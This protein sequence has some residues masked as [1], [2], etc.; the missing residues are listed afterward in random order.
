MDARTT[1]WIG[2]LALS[3]LWHAALP[4]W[5][6]QAADQYAVAA[7]HYAAK[8]W[9]LA[10]TEFRELVERHPQSPRASQSR[11]YLAECLIQSGK[12]R[13]A[14]ETLAQ[15][16]QQE[17][18][19]QLARRALFRQGEAWHLA[20]E[21]KSAEPVLR[22][23]LESY[24]DDP[25]A[26]HALCYHGASLLALRQ[27]AEASE[28]FGQALRRG[29]TGSLEEMCRLGKGQSAEQLRKEDDAAQWYEGLLAAKSSKVAQ[30]A[31]LNLGAL[32]FRRGEFASAV[33]TLK[34]LAD[35]PADN[36]LREE[37]RYWTA[38]GLLQAG[39][40]QPAL[41]IL[42]PWTNQSGPR[43]E[44]AC[45]RAATALVSLNRADEA[46]ALLKKLSHDGAWGD[47]ALLAR[48]Q[49]AVKQQDDVAVE[50]LHQEFC[51]RFPRS[52]R[53]SEVAEI[54]ARRLDAAGKHAE[55]IELLRSRLGD[56][57][58]DDDADRR[59]RY[60]LALS[61][62]GQ[63]R[64]EDALRQ[65][66]LVLQTGD[67]ELKRRALQSQGAILVS[68]GRYQE[69]IAPLA[70]SLELNPGA[71]EAAVGRGNLA[72]CYARTG[73][74]AEAK[75]ID[76]EL[77]S[78]P[79]DVAR[80]LNLLALA[81]AAAAANQRDW[82]QRLWV[83]I[84]D[85]Q[86]PVEHQLQALYSLARSQLLAGQPADAI[87]TCQKLSDRQPSGLVRA[88]AQWLRAAS[89]EKLR[90]S[91]E[92]L[93]AYRILSEQETA[94]TPAA[95]AKAAQLEQSL[96]RPDEAIQL[97]RRLASQFPEAPESDAALYQAAWL[98]QAASR[99]QE[100][101]DCFSTLHQQYPASRYWADATYRLAA[102][103][104]KS[105]QNDAVRCLVTA[106][107]E[108]SETPPE[109]LA[110]AL[111]LDVQRGVAE[112]NWT[113]VEAAANEL[114]KRVPQSQLVRVAEFWLA[115]AAYRRQ[116]TDEAVR[117]FTAL[118]QR[119]QQGQ[120]PWLA[121]VPLRLGQLAAAARDWPAARRRVEQVRRDW[122]HGDH[123]QE[124]EYL[125]GR[126]LAAEARFDE[127]RQAYTRV[128]DA[129][130]QTKTETAA[131]AQW[132]I[133]ETFL[134]QE[135]H[136]DALRAYLRVEALFAY[137]RWQAAA[138]LEAGRCYEA[139]G[140]P[141]DAIAAYQRI[142]EK[143]G[144][145]TYCDEARKRLQSATAATSPPKNS[146][147]EAAPMFSPPSSATREA[148]V[149]YDSQG[150]KTQR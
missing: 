51:R 106:L 40:H 120:D 79:L 75:Q 145:S 18:D 129:D 121:M 127:A 52:P 78:Q 25:S 23:F 67:L 140:R 123:V 47:A 14:A 54:V 49:I 137:P 76:K 13:E 86:A 91:A 12:Y 125:W 80:A 149:S 68:L 147:A 17:S 101:L 84:A 134:H 59:R 128:T 96:S 130:G 62:V 20:G 38:L 87:E 124:M 118:E 85:S 114:M 89:L 66:D 58:K 57:H 109:V 31:R 138:L 94:L 1:A 5:A 112:G 105:G 37:A 6:D 44:E 99:D 143:Y 148:A 21:P 93:Q 108:K 10:A 71:A 111:L 42:L 61:Y 15:L 7:A 142:L 113:D 126:C 83:R 115:E 43:A 141:A 33:A 8:R 4:V 53:I 24:D 144:Q 70:A 65:L 133:G 122:P 77:Q 35:L 73:R 103:A 26:L 69:A 45:Y 46:A 131:M 74:I 81:E 55:A 119:K 82:A 30:R 102:A 39:L 139:L 92:A 98:L 117:R 72:V 11:Y 48:I 135:R 41:E 104:L 60:L 100:S 88:Q 95:L 50:N 97:Y 22:K 116:Q 150:R 132:M 19:I 28:Q 3:L 146:A 110:H 16:L 2:A 107:V 29:A 63:Q 36:A 27:P 9:D 34:P 90:Q 136:E 64:H 32:Q 56:G